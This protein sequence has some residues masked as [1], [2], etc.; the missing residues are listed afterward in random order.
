V[1]DVGVIDAMVVV[2]EELVGGVMG[3]SMRN[4]K[5]MV[6]ASHDATIAAPRPS[7]W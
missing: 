3:R 1:A 7:L 2:A 4:Q 6:V 5:G